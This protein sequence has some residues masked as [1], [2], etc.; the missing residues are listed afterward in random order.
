M[1]SSAYDEGDSVSENDT[2]EFLYLSNQKVPARLR[3]TYTD[4]DSSSSVANG[5]DSEG[6]EYYYSD[7]DDLS[8]PLNLGGLIP[9]RLTSLLVCSFAQIIFEKFILIYYHLFYLGHPK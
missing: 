2:D 6:Q 4:E 9:D 8:T 3:Y 1:S 7:S 5:E